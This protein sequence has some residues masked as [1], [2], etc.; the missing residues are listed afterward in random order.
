MTQ[1]SILSHLNSLGLGSTSHPL[2]EQRAKLTCFFYFS[3]SLKLAAF[4]RHANWGRWGIVRCEF[5]SD[6]HATADKPNIYGCKATRLAPFSMKQPRWHCVD[7]DGNG[8]QADSC[9]KRDINCTTA[10]WRAWS[11]V[12]RTN[13]K[14]RRGKMKKKTVVA[15]KVFSGLPVTQLKLKKQCFSSYVRFH[16][17]SCQIN[18][19]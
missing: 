6:L 14:I 17:K 16:T 3:L 2:L 1:K 12:P 5:F 18:H 8:Y 15:K 10:C 11:K 4:T 9:A 7:D 19:V 13:M